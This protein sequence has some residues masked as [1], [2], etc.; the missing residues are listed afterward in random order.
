MIPY[1]KQQI[2]TEDIRSV[3]DVLQSDFITQGPKV[4]IFEKSIK[5]L[6]GA[7]YAV[8]LNSATSALHVACMALG[9]TKG[10]ILW[11]TPVSFVAS[12]NCGLYCGASVDF[13]DI[14]PITYNISVEA[15]EEK[16]FISEI[17]GKLPKIIVVVHLCGLP[18]DM[19]EL[20]DL[21]KRYGFKIIEDASHAIGAKYKNEFVGNCRY[22]DITVF[23]FHPVKII[24][25]AEGGM[26]VT[27]NQKLADKMELYRNHGIT[28][29]S[30]MM[31]HEPDGQWYYQQIALGYNYRMT[32]LQAALGISQL[33]RLHEFIEKRHLLFVNYAEQL[34]GL[35]IVTP[36]QISDRNSSLHLY[37]IRLQESQIGISRRE[38]FDELRKNGVGVNIHYIPIHLQPYFK[39]MGF[40]SGD[41]PEAER[42]Y[43]EAI[44]IPLHHGMTS[45]DQEKIINCIKKILSQ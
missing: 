9:L 21:S 30:D 15:L 22:S 31:T 12:A 34:T 45:N 40:K 42:Y 4:P 20:A 18:C 41:F 6:V 10:D 44:S 3:I 24:T 33:N 11:T 28:R 23:S 37:V 36:Q 14:D 43:S 13:V 1:G 17:E 39:N 16:L 8:A 7:E 26:A 2:T 38:V 19:K 35:P 27:N 25:T 29:N 32:D 5:D